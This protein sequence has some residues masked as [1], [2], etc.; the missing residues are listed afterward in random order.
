MMS[1]DELRSELNELAEQTEIL[2]APLEQVQARG[3]RRT[4]YQRGGMVLAAFA[5]VVGGTVAVTSIGGGGDD[6]DVATDEPATTSTDDTTEGD[7]DAADGTEDDRADASATEAEEESGE[8]AESTD[9]ETA[10]AVFDEAGYYGGSPRIVP[11]GDGFLSFGER[12]IESEPAEL[13]FDGASPI[14][15]YFSQEIIDTLAA[16]GATTIDE[17]M[18]VLD[19][20]GLLDEATAVVNDNPEVFEWY[21]SNIGGGT[22]EPF[23]E[24][25]ADGINWEPIDGFSWPTANQWYH[26]IAG[27][28]THLV[29]VDYQPD[30]DP[31]TGRSLPAPVIVHV[32]TD[33]STWTSIEVP[34]T[35]PTVADYV[36]L[37]VSPQ[38]LVVTDDS[39]LLTVNSWQ[40]IDIWSALPADVLDEL[41]AN[42]YDWM[43]T[44]AGI[45]IVDW[46]WEDYD[47]S[48]PISTTTV[49]PAEGG[50]EQTESEDAA[51]ESA[52]AE[53]A[54]TEDIGGWEE[55]EP[56]TIRV[57]PWSE[58]PFSY[59]E[60]T[61]AGQ[62]GGNDAQGFLGD[63]AS[64]DIAEV[65]APGQGGEVGQIVVTD[66]GLF[67]IVWDYPEVDFDEQDFDDAGAYRPT[68]TAWF[69][70]D[71]RS[72]QTRDLPAL[73]DD[74]W[75]DSAVAVENGVLLTLSS[76]EGQRFFVGAAD[77]SGFSEVDGPELP[78]YAH[79][80]FPTH[81]AMGDGAASI[82]D[83]GSA[84]EPFF[85]A[86]E[87][88]FDHDGF[89]I[90]TGQTSE[91]EGTVTVVDG[92]GATV[93]EH[94]G[95]VYDEPAFQYNENGMT[96][97]DDDGETIVTIPHEVM[98][99]EVWP[100][101]SQAWEEYHE[102]N[103]Y[104]P[105]FW[106]IATRDGRTWTTMQLPA[107]D[108]EYG[109]YGD[110]VVAGDRVLFSD[111]MGDWQVIPL[112]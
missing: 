91:G 19:D 36:Q 79:V 94:T 39:W 14:G 12:F 83:L 11:W 46:G 21:T 69:S 27:N 43:P 64:G 26:Q 16:S 107:L 95:H 108:D 15:D 73:G 51:A 29:A 112:S 85:P 78:E 87:V 70:T 88:T 6:L 42:G 55:P 58:M 84:A 67:T 66:A 56:T 9:V 65:E 75:L 4:M 100:I 77:G 40:W 37:D 54:L 111:G 60:Y 48:Y 10:E 92:E 45:E 63:L 105:D 98:E 25:S 102:A 82:I 32:T 57:I 17:A 28:G 7:A 74:D 31:E 5:L 44:E 101:E 109:W 23:A 68:I 93:F 103:P 24:F 30:W 8:A 97:V 47:E 1:D 81:V 80:W 34:Y 72:W 110:A 90:T 18:G 50:T 71:G 53:E 61:G 86:Y 59:E 20:A 89:E 38:Q 104:V 3:R 33:L 99:Q 22:Y 106:L 96:I 76:G 52:A 49:L 2:P 41:S 62:G 35:A 13:V